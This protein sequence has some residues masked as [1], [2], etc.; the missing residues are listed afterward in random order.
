MGTRT[1]NVIEQEGKL[2]AV[3]QARLWQTGRY[4]VL[5]RSQEPAKTPYPDTLHSARQWAYWG[6]DDRFPTTAR[7]AIEKVPMAG[8]A[9]L[10]RAEMLYGNG[11]AYYRRDDLYDADG[12]R[13]PRASIRKIDD[14][15]RRNR[16]NTAWYMPQA[17]DFAALANSFSEIIFTNDKRQV[18]GIFHKTGEH[19]RRSVQNPETLQSE[20]VLFSRRFGDVPRE[21]EIMRIP[22]YDYFDEERFLRRLQGY[23]MAWHTMLDT[24][25]SIYYARPP[26]LGLFREDGWLDVSCAVPEIVNSMMRNQITLKYQIN[27]PESYFEMVYPD[28]DNYTAEQRDEAF[29]ELVDKINEQLVGTRNA[30]RSISFVFRQD[31]ITG[32]EMGKVEIVAI[33]DKAKN[34]HWIPSSEKADAQIVQGFGI[35]PSQLGLATEGGKMGAGSGSDQRE[36]Y[37]TAITLNT[38]E[39]D[40][41]LEPL[42]WIARYN[43]QADPDWDVVF[44]IDHTMHTTTNLKESGLLPSPTTLE[45]VPPENA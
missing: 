32:K 15:L 39:Q 16:V 23:K 43:A 30:F 37:N 28:W 10:R 7:M 6:T 9:I 44:F 19:C 26:W 20:Y 45:I 31:P 41:L 17:L 36:S 24:P 1:I 33:D 27:V 8:Q 11:I 29:S 42:N 34:D 4:G 35:H 13:V 25:G 18:S 38:P 12:P 2:T 21:D 3:P 14:W 22:C 40:L 5:D